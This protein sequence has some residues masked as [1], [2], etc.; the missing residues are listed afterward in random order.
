MEIVEGVMNLSFTFKFC[1]YCILSYM[2]KDEEQISKGTQPFIFLFIVVPES[3][4]KSSVL[5]KSLTFFLSNMAMSGITATCNCFTTGSSSG[6][7]E[8]FTPKETDSY[9]RYAL[10]D[11]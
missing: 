2:E 10:Q 4:K 3:G 7:S 5:F 1:R 9:N 6:K 8:V 11:A